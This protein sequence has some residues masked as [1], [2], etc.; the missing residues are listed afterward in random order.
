MAKRFSEEAFEQVVKTGWEDA[1]RSGEKISYE[2]F[3]KE[4]YRNFATMVANHLERICESYEE[5][6]LEPSI[7]VAMEY[8][9]PF[10]R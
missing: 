2:D 6:G 1:R 7:K 9:D 5:G 4:C 8:L 10:V 3:K